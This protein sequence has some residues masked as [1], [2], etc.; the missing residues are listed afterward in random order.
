MLW[1]LAITVNVTCLFLNVPSSQ[2]MYD[3]WCFRCHQKG[4]LLGERKVEDLRNRIE[5][6]YTASY[7]LSVKGHVSSESR[8]SSRRSS[9]GKRSTIGTETSERSPFQG[10]HYPSGSAMDMPDLQEIELGAL[11]DALEQ[12]EEE[13]D[14][15][16]VAR[17]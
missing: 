5:R 14:Y 1:V 10:P 7:H 8:P 4:H 11:H 13:E 17:T 16:E 3:K 2:A 9:K 6:Q 15:E 12:E